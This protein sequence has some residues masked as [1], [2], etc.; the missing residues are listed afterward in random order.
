MP[1]SGLLACGGLVILMHVKDY[2]RSTTTL[3]SAI[4]H[5]SCLLDLEAD[6]GTGQI[7]S[8]QIVGWILLQIL[9]YPSDELELM[10]EILKMPEERYGIQ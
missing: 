2:R 8:M 1:K 9:F 4:L 5:A 10:P 7:V 6:P 3:L